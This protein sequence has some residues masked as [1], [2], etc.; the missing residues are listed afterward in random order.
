MLIYL[1]FIQTLLTFVVCKGDVHKILVFNDMHLN[2]NFTTNHCPWSNCTDLGYKGEE[3]PELTDSP[4]LLIDTVLDRAKSQVEANEEKVEAIIIT[5]DFIVHDFM[6]TV[7]TSD[8][9][10]YQWKMGLLQGIW[11]E[12]I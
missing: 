8:P 7:N 3:Y 12:T 4:S 11:K 10:V 6:K 5:G 2:P 9:A 1:Y